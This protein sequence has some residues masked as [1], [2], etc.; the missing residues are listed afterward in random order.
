MQRIKQ[1]WQ[2]N[3]IRGGSLISEDTELSLCSFIH[4]LVRLVLFLICN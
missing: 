1:I 4:V 3:R 2:L